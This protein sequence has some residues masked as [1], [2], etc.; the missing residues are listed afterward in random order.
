MEEYI[1]VVEF[2]REG[3]WWLNRWPDLFDCE[4][5]LLL[6][7]TWQGRSYKTFYSILKKW[8][9]SLYW[10][11]H[12]VNK[13]KCVLKSGEIILVHALYM[14]GLVWKSDAIIWCNCIML[15]CFS[16]CSY[17]KE[18]FWTRSHGLNSFSVLFGQECIASNNLTSFL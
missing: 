5:C 4:A 14:F 10:V 7:L 6:S 17:W 2:N 12:V 1:T 16:K 9:N 11:W 3:Y 18:V 15:T 13:F 8:C